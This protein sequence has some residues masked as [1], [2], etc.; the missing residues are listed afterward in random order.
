MGAAS[1]AGER[2]SAGR[3]LPDE[4]VAGLTIF[5]LAARRHDITGPLA[6]AIGRQIGASGIAEQ[7]ETAVLREG[8]QPWNE[9]RR[10][11]LFVADVAG[12]DDLPARVESADQVRG[13]H[14]KADAVQRRI[15]GNRSRGEVIGIGGEHMS[16]AGGCRGESYETRSGAEIE[17]RAAD[18]VFAMIEEIAGQRLAADPGEGP[19]RRR[20]PGA[21]E[22]LF[23]RLPDRCDL[24]RQVKPDL[25]DQ[26]WC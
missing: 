7:H 19:K 14:F 10:H 9:P 1:A 17:N 22:N 4:P 8:L 13:R 26:W 24:G 21:G 18:D 11:G 6:E 15:K 23:G 3:N 2:G 12:S 5:E 16:S 20:Q 25:R